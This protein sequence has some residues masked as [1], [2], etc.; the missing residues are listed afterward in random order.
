MAATVS[1]FGYSVP[2]TVVFVVIALVLGLALAVLFWL[3]IGLSVYRSVHQTR[4]QRVRDELQE[5]FLDRLFDPEADWDPWVEGLSAVEREVVESLLDEYLRE[6]DGQHVAKL[7]ELGDALGIPERSE[8]QLRGR[9]EYGH[10]AALTWLTLLARP[11]RLRD[12][13][14]SPQTPRERAAVVR[15]RYESDD[16]DEP[17]A[18]IALLLD[19]V[20]EQFTVFGQDTLYRVA[21]DDPGALFEIAT[22]NYRAWS[23]PLLIQVL[24]V[25]HHI[26]RNVTTEDLSWLI[27]ALEHESEAVRAAAARALGNVGWRDDVREA[28]FF[29]RFTRDHSPRV[30]GAVYQML[31]RIGDEQTLAEL[32]RELRTEDDPRARLVGTRALVSRRDRLQAEASEALA[33]SWGWSREHA[34]YDRVARE[35]RTQAGD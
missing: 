26:G 16:F 1:A 5:Q 23:E 15:L 8:R 17:E 19:G 24:L 22:E 10:L 11:E 32:T 33:N 3:T 31:A 27:T 13:D 21:T 30:R 25:C 2:L 18:G 4:R 34:E 12:A 6:L 29:G 20:T 7:R 9:D 28:L 35:R 14:F